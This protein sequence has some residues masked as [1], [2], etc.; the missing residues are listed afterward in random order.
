MVRI[1]SIQRIGPRGVI[2][3]VSGSSVG[4]IEFPSALSDEE[5]KKRIPGLSDVGKAVPA[6]KPATPVIRPATAT[7]GV[8]D[9]GEKPP[10]N[11]NHKPPV[12]LKPK[13]GRGRAKK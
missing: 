1:L 7:G 3:Y 13:T 5:A 6:P 11:P 4:A 9:G 12:N 2:Q 8:K 10:V